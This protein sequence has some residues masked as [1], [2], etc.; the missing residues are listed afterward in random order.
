MTNQPSVPVVLLAAV[1]LW[2]PSME[3]FINGD[4]DVAA[5]AIRFGLSVAVAWIGLAVILRVVAKYRTEGRR[6]AGPGGSG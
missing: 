5:A 4:L 2:F 1:A 3:A 6:R